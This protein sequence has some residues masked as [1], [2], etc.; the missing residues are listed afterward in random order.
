MNTPEGMEAAWAE[1]LQVLPPDPIV[2]IE[3]RRKTG[4]WAARVGRA[5]RTGTTPAE[6]LGAVAAALRRPR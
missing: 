3:L 1:L 4:Q 2:R 5:T 6:A